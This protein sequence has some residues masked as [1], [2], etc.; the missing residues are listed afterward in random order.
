MKIT[1][2]FIKQHTDKYFSNT[3]KIVADNGDVEVVYGFFVRKPSIYAVKIA[4]DFLNEIK[5]SLGYNFTVYENFKEGDKVGAGDPLFFIEGSLKELSELETLVLQKVGLSC[6][7]A[8]NAYSMAKALPKANFISMLARH[9]VDENMVYACEYGSSVGS[10]VAINEGSLGFIGSSNDA[11]AHLFNTKEGFGTMPHA[12]IGYAGSTLNAAKMYYN[13]FKPKTMSILVD[14]FGKEITDTL[15]LCEHFKDLAYS[16]NLSVRIDTHGN[17]Y[18]EGLD[19]H[20]SYAVIEKYIPSA[21]H[22]YKDEEEIDYLVGMGV[23]GAAIFYLREKLDKAGFNN[24]KIIV[25]SGF[26]LKKCLLMS[27]INAPI[28]SVGTGSY[29]P[30]N[31]SDTYTTAD[32]I[33]YNG[34]LSVKVGR[35]FLIKKW[36]EKLLQLQGK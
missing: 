22:D 23:S 21:F 5:K 6:L 16:G 2:D 8:W 25:S 18:L 10:K 13:S 24:V 26:N 1:L 29:I 4:I 11:T 36:Q 12:L 3:S 7:C 20:K 27:K 35:E 15:E 17:R 19:S 28:S 34:K 9:C 32:V 30:Q 14:Y 31:W 33:S